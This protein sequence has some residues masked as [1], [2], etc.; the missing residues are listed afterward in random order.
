MTHPPTNI[1]HPADGSERPLLISVIGGGAPSVRAYELAEA[2]GRELAQRGA[3]VVCGGLGGV[4]EAACKGAKSAGGVTIGLMPGSDP[5]TANQWVDYPVMTGM[6]YA[7]NVI[8]VKTGRAAIAVDGAY[9]TLSE[10]AHALGDGTPV[11]G[12]ET[13]E[14]QSG[15]GYPLEI[16]R[17]DSPVDAVEKAIA[18][19]RE[20]DARERAAAH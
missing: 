6:G 5:R 13:W 7:R 4:M 18:A 15:D 10:I 1:S 9:G 3:V 8:V 14:M 17:A 2:V 20:R 11:I 16:T 12:L 19:A